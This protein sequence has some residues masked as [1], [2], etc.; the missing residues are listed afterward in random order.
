MTIR[1]IE[2]STKFKKDFK[3]YLRQENKKRKILE[4][5]KILADGAGIPLAMRPHRLIGNYL[6]YI[7]LHIEG[8]LLLIWLEKNELGEEIIILTRVGSHAEL[9]GK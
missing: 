6:G 9:F 1:R 7:E 8:D 5:I 4:A 2:Y 3:R